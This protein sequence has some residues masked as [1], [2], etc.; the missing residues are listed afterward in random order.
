MRSFVLPQRRA[1]TAADVE[2]LMKAL[3]QRHRIQSMAVAFRE[4]LLLRVSAQVYVDEQDLDALV[5]ALSQ[6][7]WPGR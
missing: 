4:S 5:A 3:W 6:D 2:V 7:G 1:A